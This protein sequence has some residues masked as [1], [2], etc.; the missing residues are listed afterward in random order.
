VAIFV[1]KATAAQRPV[2]I[3]AD[4][5]TGSYWRSGDGDFRMHPD[6]V[7]GM[8]AEREKAAKNQSEE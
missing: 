7:R 8:L 6:V 5:F 1:P 2:Y 4:P 3:G